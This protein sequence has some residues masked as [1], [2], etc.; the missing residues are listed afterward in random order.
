MHASDLP[1]SIVLD[2]VTSLCGELL[3]KG[4]SR[5]VYAWSP[6][7]ELVLKLETGDHFQNVMEWETW[8]K[9]KETKHACWLAPPVWIS[10]CGTALLMHRTAP[11]RR[12][13]EPESLPAWLS[14][15]KRRN[16]GTLLGR[17]VCHDYGTNL[18]L[19]H[20]AAAG[21]M[22]RCEYWND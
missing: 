18:L 15:H 12:G 19:N 14:D 9:A 22:K 10:G 11:L 5:E 1:R 6:N 4:M 13:E 17:V 16:F 8:W 2:L 21:R 7:E 20:G 3:G